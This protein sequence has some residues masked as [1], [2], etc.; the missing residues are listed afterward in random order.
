MSNESFV[1]GRRTMGGGKDG[2]FR[3]HSLLLV[4]PLSP[5]V[6]PPS[7]PMW[8]SEWEKI[9]SCGDVEESIKFILMKMKNIGIPVFFFPIPTQ[10]ANFGC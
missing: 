9:S 5:P 6:H 1:K 4:T 7:L 10:K 2:D 8:P 3:T